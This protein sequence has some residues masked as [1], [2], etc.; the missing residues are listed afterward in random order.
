MRPAGSAENDTCPIA[1][2]V[3]P[4]FGDAH[5]PKQSKEKVKRKK[6]AAAATPCP[7]E[8][9]SPCC[10]AASSRRKESDRRGGR[11]SLGAADARGSRNCATVV[12]QSG[13]SHNDQPRSGSQRRNNVGDREAGDEWE[14]CR[15][16]CVLDAT[17]RPGRASSGVVT[18]ATVTWFD[19]SAAF[20]ETRALWS[21]TDGRTRPGTGLQAAVFV[22]GVEWRRL[23]GRS[24]T[25]SGDDRDA[26]IR[27][28]RASTSKAISSAGISSRC[29]S[30]R[31]AIPGSISAPDPATATSRLRWEP[32]LH[33]HSKSTRRN[34]CCS[35]CA[36]CRAWPRTRR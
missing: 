14:R 24:G 8:A 25:G 20:S 28:R 16:R 15:G 29:H 2:S 32:A 5:H 18:L 36:P 26:T 35:G 19:A 6:A 33:G 9:A 22:Q 7:H 1:V 34:P 31:D 21:A 12:E 11:S 23:P 4:R 3:P 27:S 13:I 17:W 30:L 10:V